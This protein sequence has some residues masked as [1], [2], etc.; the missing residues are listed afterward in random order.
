MSPCWKQAGGPPAPPGIIRGC[1]STLKRSDLPTRAKKVD[2][3][4]KYYDE[5][6]PGGLGVGDLVSSLLW[7]QFCP[8]PGDFHA[9][10]RRRK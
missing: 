2:G 8:W 3:S 9:T 7:L 4:E 1:R 5:E 6:A 10:G